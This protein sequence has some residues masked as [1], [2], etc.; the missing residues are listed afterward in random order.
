MAGPESSVGPPWPPEGYTEVGSYAFGGPFIPTV[1]QVE[2]AEEF[3]FG[4]PT[5]ENLEE[6]QRR[7][8]VIRLAIHHATTEAF[9]GKGL[10]LIPLI[11][12][13]VEVKF[14]DEDGVAVREYHIVK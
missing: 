2:E 13:N 1:D 14:R 9:R 10:G 6:E 5:F 11:G 8:N 3:V 7:R 4:N 12:A